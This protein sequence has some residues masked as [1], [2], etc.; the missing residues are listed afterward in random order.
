MELELQEANKATLA[1]SQGQVK[2]KSIS[3]QQVAEWWWAQMVAGQ[4]R[5]QSDGGRSR[6]NGA[7]PKGAPVL[8]ILHVPSLSRIPEGKTWCK[9]KTEVMIAEKK[10][11]DGLRSCCRRGRS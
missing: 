4:K 3:V 9:L 2:E 6:E 10:T 11:G 5:L 1:C 7:S 8:F